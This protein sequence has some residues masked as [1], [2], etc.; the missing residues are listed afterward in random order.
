MISFGSINVYYIYCCFPFLLSLCIDFF[1]YD[2]IVDVV[3]RLIYY[4]L[5]ILCCTSQF[6]DIAHHGTKVIIYNLWLNDDG[7]FELDFDDDDEVIL[8]ILMFHFGL[9]CTFP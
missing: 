8:C 6:E 5:M 4:I 2:F 1:G 7:I 3:D 9:L